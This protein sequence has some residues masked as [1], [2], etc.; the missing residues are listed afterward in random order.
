[1]SAERLVIIQV[2]CTKKRVT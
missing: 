1:L 2:L